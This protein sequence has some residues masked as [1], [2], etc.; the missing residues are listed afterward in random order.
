MACT[1]IAEVIGVADGHASV[2]E[3]SS[4]IAKSLAVRSACSQASSAGSVQRVIPDTNPAA[5][6]G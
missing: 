4:A 6:T 5:P 1:M 3:A 2:S